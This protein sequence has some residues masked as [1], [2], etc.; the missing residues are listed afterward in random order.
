MLGAA[1]HEQDR[2]V[3]FLEKVGGRVAEEQRLARA[4]VDAEDDEI[5]AADADLAQDRCMRLAERP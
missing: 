2:G 1:G 4:A 3:G 5:M